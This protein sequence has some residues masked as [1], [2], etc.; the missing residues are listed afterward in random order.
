M[1]RGRFTLAAA[2][3]AALVAGGA[4]RTRADEPAAEPAATPSAQDRAAALALVR[5]GNRL[6]DAGDPVGALAM[7]QQAHRLV[8]G[9]K[10]HFNFGQALAAIPGREADAYRELEL[11]LE[12]VPAATPDVVR[13]AHREQDRLR[14]RLGFLRV[15]TKADHVDIQIDG[16]PAGTSPLRRSLALAPGAHAIA[17]SAPGFLPYKA[18]VTLV[19]GREVT[20]VVELAPVPLAAPAAPPPAQAPPVVEAPPP[21]PPPSAAAA[22]PQAAPAAPVAASLVTTPAAAPAPAPGESEPVFKRWWFWAAVGGAVALGAVSVALLSRGTD[23]N[24]VCPQ[25]ASQCGSAP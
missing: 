22:L 15:E 25:V 21:A 12:R 16:K 9:D 19:A 10:L 4:G 5:E 6:L 20:Q 18:D 3:A 17:A 14:A 2:L 24:H 1:H 11:F 7:F 8:G 23:V 13:A